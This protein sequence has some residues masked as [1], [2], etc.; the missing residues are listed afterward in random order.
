LSQHPII[1]FK[2]PHSLL[3][4]TFTQINK[5][6]FSFLLFITR[7][8]DLTPDQFKTHWDT[9]HVEL[10]KSIAGNKF[11]TS[12][13]RTYISRPAELNASWPATVLV[14]SQEDFSYDGIAELIFK[15]EAAFQ[16]FFSVVNEPVNAAKIA[17]DEEAFIVREAMRAVVIGSK[18]FTTG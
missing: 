12:H 3:N 14:G 7:R 9:K 10:L 17:A 16:A 5:M 18:S 4:L 8:P 13:T 11:P 15:D 1:L 2:A 6:S